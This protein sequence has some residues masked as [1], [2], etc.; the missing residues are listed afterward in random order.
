MEECKEICSLAL[1]AATQVKFLV[2]FRF[3]SC[4]RC[5]CPSLRGVDNDNESRTA[6][7][8]ERRTAESGVGRIR[9]DATSN[10]DRV[11]LKFKN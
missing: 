2:L 7:P 11:F 6:A 5:V 4:S 9:S 10:H 1:S 3:D 8:T